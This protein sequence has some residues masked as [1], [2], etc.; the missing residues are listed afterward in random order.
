M[1][2]DLNEILRSQELLSDEHHRFLLYQLLRGLK[3]IHSA[4]IIHRDLVFLPDFIIFSAFN[5][6]T[7]KP[8]C[9]PRLS[10]QNL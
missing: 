6:E 1:P 10:A 4:N 5:P 7:E 8:A 2:Y 9:E 3:Y